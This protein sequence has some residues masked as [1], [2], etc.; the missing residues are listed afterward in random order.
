MPSTT[1]AQNAK[2]YSAVY[3]DLQRRF[4]GYK[5]VAK[6]ASSLMAFFAALMGLFTSGFS[7]YITTIGLTTYMPEDDIAANDWS[8]LAHEGVHVGDYAAS[9]FVYNLGY[10]MPQLLAAGSLLSF[11]ALGAIGGNLAWLWCLTALA[12]I[13]FLFLPSPW[14]TSRER[15]AYLMSMCMDA[16]RYGEAYILSESYITIR[17]EEFTTGAYLWMDPFSSAV[18]GWV[19][20]DRNRALAIVRGQYDDPLYSPAVALVRAAMA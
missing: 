13:G 16:L 4:P 3:A 2:I 14:R 15:K 11:G 8:T 19:T 1:A 9:A 18:H 7:H 20:N 12:S 5:V 6:E 10:M 17:V